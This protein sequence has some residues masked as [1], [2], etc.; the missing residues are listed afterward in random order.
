MTSLCD[1]NDNARVRTASGSDRPGYAVVPTACACVRAEAKQ[2]GRLRTQDPVATG[3]CDC[4]LIA[5]EVP[6][7]GNPE[8]PTAQSND[9]VPLAVLTRW[10]LTLKSYRSRNP[11]TSILVLARSSLSVNPSM[12]IETGMVLFG[13]SSLR[14]VTGITTIVRCLT[15]WFW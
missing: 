14:P 7:I 1:D 9:P 4:R 13:S 15:G 11:V 3:S 2:S 6:S 8:I 5:D 12:V 10:A